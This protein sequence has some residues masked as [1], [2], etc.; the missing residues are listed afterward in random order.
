[1]L[2]MIAA[3]VARDSKS[4][5]LKEAEEMAVVCELHGH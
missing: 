2:L 5:E 1:M 4:Y 3:I